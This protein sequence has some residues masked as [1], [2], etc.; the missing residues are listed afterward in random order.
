MGPRVVRVR[1]ALVALALVAFAGPGLAAEKKEPTRMVVR[2]LGHQEDGKYRYLGKPVMVVA[3]EPI[4]G[5]RPVELAVPNRDQNSNK[6]DPIPQVAEAVRTS[7]AGDVLKIELDDAK[8]RPWLRYAKPYKLKP[9]E[10]DPRAYT[11]QNSFRKEEGHSTYTA[12]V[13][14]RYDE[15]L[16]VAVQQK[17]DKEGDMVSD[18]QVLDLLQKLKT[19]E[20]VEADIRREGGRAVLT[21]LERYAAPQNGKFVKSTEVEVEGQKAPAVELERGGKAVTAVVVG[22]TQGKR[23]APD[24]KVMAAVKKLKPDAEVTFRCRDDDGK[25]WL[26]EIEPAKKEEPEG[27][28]AA[29]AGRGAEDD[30]RSR[31]ADK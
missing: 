4:E 11:F 18:G 29:R 22:K 15:P 25:L 28:A 1:A 19:G 16:T 23:W 14:S 30:K 9:G 10:D 8:P 27:A 20:L 3:V 13:L 12:V 26:K 6:V 5:G 2:Y 31:K 24:A 7:K 21:S 17:K